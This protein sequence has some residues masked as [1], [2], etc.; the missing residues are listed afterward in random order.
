MIEIVMMNDG[1]T[2]NITTQNA[3]ST[4]P[5]TMSNEFAMKKRRNNLYFNRPF[6][7]RA[8]PRLTAT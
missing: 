8:F 3:G 6:T 1:L 5:I 4:T 2:K 7:L